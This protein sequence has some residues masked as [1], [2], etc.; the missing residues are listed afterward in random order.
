VGRGWARDVLN[1]G[2]EGEGSAV[3]ARDM[4]NVERALSEAG[5]QQPRQ[6]STKYAPLPCPLENQRLVTVF[7]RV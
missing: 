4:L 1:G 2:I 6:R 7:F 3:G 5:P